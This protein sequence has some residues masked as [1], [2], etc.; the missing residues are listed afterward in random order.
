M[1]SNYNHDQVARW[2]KHIASFTTGEVA[3]FCA[4]DS[5]SAC[6]SSE[7]PA[8]AADDDD[9]FG[10]VEEDTEEERRELECQK[11]QV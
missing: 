3:S 2:Y 7:A 8:A 1:I 10:D 5:S 4:C 9:M 6:C 11:A